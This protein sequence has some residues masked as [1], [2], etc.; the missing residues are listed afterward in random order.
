M[1]NWFNNKST[2]GEW[3]DWES[4]SRQFIQRTVEQKST[5]ADIWSCDL[6]DDCRVEVL[7]EKNM[8]ATSIK[9]LQSSLNPHFDAIISD[10]VKAWTQSAEFQF[11]KHIYKTPAKVMIEVG[12]HEKDTCTGESL[13][14]F[15][16]G[17]CKRYNG[18]AGMGWEARELMMF[19][20]RLKKQ[21]LYSHESQELFKDGETEKDRPV[22]LM[23]SKPDEAKDNSAPMKES[24]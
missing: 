17:K 19:S 12:I 13:Q 7:L 2:L 20:K 15:V 1:G 8:R 5:K 23:K 21:Y 4:K 16:D 9:V 11:P 18:C 24:N 10:T 3:K 6:A 14:D 22:E